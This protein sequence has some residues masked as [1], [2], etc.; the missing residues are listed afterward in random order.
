M[1]TETAQHSQQAET[2]SGPLEKAAGFAILLILLIIFAYLVLCIIA[3]TW[4]HFQLPISNEDMRNA[5]FLS[6]RMGIQWHGSVFGGL[7]VLFGVVNLLGLRPSGVI[8]VVL[9]MSTIFATSETDALRQ[10]I[11]DRDMK[12]GCF[13]Y[14]SL[15][16]REQLN[17]ST[18]EARSIYRNKSEMREGGFA[19]WYKPIRSNAKLHVTTSLPNTFPGVAFLK[20]PVLVLSHMDELSEMITVQRNE[21]SN[22]KAAQARK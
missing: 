22:F 5:S 7:F 8:L 9:G 19:E 10:G 13:S 12:I 3:S 20:S 2:K 17:V 14:E 1:I 15:E 16:C 18:G 4:L 6:L 11:L 21:V